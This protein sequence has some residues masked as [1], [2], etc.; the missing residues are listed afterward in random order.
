[1]GSP[2]LILPVKYAAGK[3]INIPNITAPPISFS[4][5]N[6]GDEPTAIITAKVFSLLRTHIMSAIHGNGWGGYNN[7]E[8]TTEDELCKHFVIT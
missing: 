4:I 6:N 5:T 8:S 2:C 1:M 7:I 3:P